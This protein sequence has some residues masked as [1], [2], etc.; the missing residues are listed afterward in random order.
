MIVQSYL[1]VSHIGRMRTIF[2]T[3]H[4]QFTSEIPVDGTIWLVLILGLFL[5]AQYLS[6]TTNGSSK[7]LERKVDLILK[8]LGLDP[9]QDVNPQVI[10]LLKSGQKIQ[11][12]KLY[13]EQTGAGLKD[14]KDYVEGL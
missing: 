4:S 14:A 11:A 2:Q 7:R 10:E 12:I 5:M 1:T 9:Y 6:T 13:R 3:R 8:H